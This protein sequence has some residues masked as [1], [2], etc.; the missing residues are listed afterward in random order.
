MHVHPRHSLALVAVLLGVAAPANASA[1]TGSIHG[2]VTARGARAPVSGYEVD[3]YDAG[4]AKL[5]SVCTAGDGTYAFTQLAT[6]NYYV[7][8]AGRPG[9]GSFNLAPAWFDGRGAA[10][11]ADPV[12]VTDGADTPHIDASLLDGASIRGIVT[13]ADSGAPVANV[14]V[15]VW[16]L[17]G[18]E[19]ARDCTGADGRYM[20]WALSG[21]VDSVQFVADGS[22]GAVAPYPT[23]YYDDADTAASASPVD[24]ATGV[25]NDG[26]DAHLKLHPTRTLTVSVAGAGTVTS[27]PAGISCPGTC[28]AAFASGTS[29]ALSA[30]PASGSTFSRWNGDCGGTGSCALTLSTDAAVG[31]SF[32]ATGGS[33]TPPATTGG[34]TNPPAATP[35]SKPSCRLSPAAKVKAGRL[36]V[37]IGCDQSAKLTLTGS[38]KYRRGKHTT[39]I[40]LKRSTVTAAKRTVTL[41]LSSKVTGALKAKLK[42]SAS[43]KLVASNANGTATVSAT[44]RRLAV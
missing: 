4:R 38:V 31:A 44:V 23:R 11:F 22:C 21:G 16:D 37:V 25:V 28:T 6:G 34:G 7:S 19:L 3:L 1:A 10:A 9:C 40:R 24:L 14:S 18:A 8:F 35:A 41:K 42:V 17:S 32:T 13:D 12:A 43:L 5:G 29:V 20:V 30:A 15:R 27:Y 39:T 26:V 2:T 36:T 33:T